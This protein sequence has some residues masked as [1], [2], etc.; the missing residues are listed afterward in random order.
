MTTLLNSWKAPLQ[1][2]LIRQTEHPRIAIV[3]IGN[4]FRSD[5]AAGVLVAHKLIRADSVQNLDTVLVMDA[6][7]APEYSTGE[8][9]RFAPDVVILIDAADMGETPGTIRWIEMDDLDGMSASTHSMPLSMLASYLTLAL[10]CRVA[11][12]GIQPKSNDV[13]ESISREV[14]EAVDEVINGLIESLS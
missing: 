10:D 2:L 3:G 7:H 6:G 9:R 8:L 12:L 4:A 13:G 14:S 11:L 1:L 5:D